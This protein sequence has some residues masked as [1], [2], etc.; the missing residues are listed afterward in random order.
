MNQ[1]IISGYYISTAR[2]KQKIG[3]SPAR[4]G[5]A[6]CLSL[7]AMKAIRRQEEA[8]QSTLPATASRARAGVPASALFWASRL[9]QFRAS[10]PWPR[11]SNRFEGH[12]GRSGN[13]CRCRRFRPVA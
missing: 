9:W 5:E 2:L 13:R 7:P 6:H 12:S 11:R 4:P 10:D 8:I 1:S 3:A